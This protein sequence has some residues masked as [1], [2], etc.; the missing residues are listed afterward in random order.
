VTLHFALVA[1]VSIASLNLSLLVNSVGFYQI[2]KLLI[3]PF[4][5]AVELL[6][7]GRRFT[8]PILASIGLV[9]VGVAIVCV[10]VGG[11]G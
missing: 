10:F 3:I 8:A 5:C 6:W 4:V 9:I 1:N 2:A 7:M 11:G